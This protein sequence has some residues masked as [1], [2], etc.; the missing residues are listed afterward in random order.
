[1]AKKPTSSRGLHT[2]VKSAKRRS[3]SSTKWLARQLN[4]PY[5]QQSKA[6]GYRSRA[7]YK[8]LEIQEKLHILKPGQT[9]I[10]L[11]AAPGSWLQIAKEAI[12]NGPKG[13][14]IAIDL[15]DID[16]MEGVEFLQADFTQE[17]TIAWLK[18]HVPKGVDVILSDMAPNT[19][20]NS[21]L[22]HL[23]IMGLCEEVFLFASEV[24]RPGG[25]VVCKAFQGGTEQQLLK[26]IKKQ[27][28][29]TKHIKPKASRKDSA[30][31]YLAA[32]GYKTPQ[33]TP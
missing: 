3:N 4:D 22:D 17:E 9:V 1:M 31:L 6:D 10:D 16:P 24:L 19:T 21:S 28:T 7:A 30:E 20:G 11:G 8:L 5:V 33:A 14:L 2:R 18:T 32:I 25:S 12:N 29:A 27:Y 26:E 13:K 23:R 15:L